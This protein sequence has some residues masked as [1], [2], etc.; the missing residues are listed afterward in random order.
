MTDGGPAKVGQVWNYPY[1]WSHEAD[2]GCI[3]GTKLR[4]TAVSL[5]TTHKNGDAVVLLVPMTTLEPKDNPFAV[6]L[7]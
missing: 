5:L 2:A 6:D 7:P 3:D 4:P 1:L